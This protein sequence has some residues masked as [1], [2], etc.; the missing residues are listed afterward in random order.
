VEALAASTDGPGARVHFNIRR[1]K[2]EN[3]A[4]YTQSEVARD[5]IESARAEGR[6]IESA[7][8]YGA[9]HEKRRGL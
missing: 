6:E 9:I 2:H 4:A 1:L 3:A 5:I 7:R 8:G